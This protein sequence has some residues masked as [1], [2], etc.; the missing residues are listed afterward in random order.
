M[1]AGDFLTLKD[2]DAD[3]EDTLAAAEDAAVELDL[4]LDRL[5]REY[6]LEDGWYWTVFADGSCR[7]MCG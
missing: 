5:A 3:F 2:T 1:K 4:A 6:P 7:P